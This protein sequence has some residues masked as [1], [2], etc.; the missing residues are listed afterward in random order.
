RLVTVSDLDADKA[1]LLH[2]MLLGRYPEVYVRIVF[3]NYVTD[4]SIDEH[5]VEI[6]ILS[7][8]EDYNRL[9]T[10]SYPGSHVILLCSRAN[11]PTAATKKNII[12]K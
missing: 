9:R 12:E 11:S 2:T 5:Q 4:C 8:Q 1:L 6:V 3:K 10:L 7:Q